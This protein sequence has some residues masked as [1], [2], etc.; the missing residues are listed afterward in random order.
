MQ[1]HSSLQG[2]GPRKTGR[3][4]GPGHPTGPL[5]PAPDPCPIPPAEACLWGPGGG[6]EECRPWTGI[7]VQTK[8]QDWL[9]RK[10]YQSSPAVHSWVRGTLRVDAGSLHPPPQS[11]GDEGLPLSFQS[12]PASSPA[13]PTR[14]PAYPPPGC[15]QRL[16]VLAWR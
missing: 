12:L 2:W 11:F 14:V 3:L 5:A 13:R 15:A 10:S 16:P 9:G 8:A 4:A 1:Q 7:A 6:G